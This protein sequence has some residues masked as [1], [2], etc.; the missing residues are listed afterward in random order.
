MK[1]LLANWIW[2]ILA[3]VS[4]RAHNWVFDPKRN[5]RIRMKHRKRWWAYDSKAARTKSKKDDMRA[6]AWKIQFNFKTSP[7]AAK[8]RGDLI[9]PAH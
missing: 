8:H 9:Y 2:D 5:A 4:T 3:L 1:T 7:G 6:E